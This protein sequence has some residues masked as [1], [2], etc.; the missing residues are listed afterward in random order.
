MALYLSIVIQE[1]DE[2]TTSKNKQIAKNTVALYIRMLFTTI[3]SLYTSRVVLRTLG[4]DD[5]GL[6]GLVGGVVAMLGFINTALSG[7]TSRFITY[8]LG[9]NDRV[10]L[11]K[12]FSSAKLIHIGIAVVLFVV[13]ET[14][15]LWIVNSQLVIPSERVVAANIVYQCSI[16]TS[17]MTILQVPY[18]AS[19][20]AHEKMD[21]YAIIEIVNT[22]LKLLIVYLLLV[23]S[24]DKLIIYSVFLLLV[25]VMV[26]LTYRIY[27]RRKFEECTT[28]CKSDKSVLKPMLVFAGWDLYGN[29]SVTVRQQGVNILL[30][31]FYGLAVN[32]AN[33]I[34][35][36]FN[37]A[38]SGFAN[39]IVV[40][41]RPQIVKSYS[42][43]D[44][45][46]FNTLLVNAIQ[47]SSLFVIM[48]SIPCFF[49]ME[50]ILEIWLKEVPEYTTSFCRISLIASCF[51]I[52]NTVIGAGIHATGDVKRISLITGT[53]FLST[54]FFAYVLLRLGFE[55]DSVYVAYCVIILGVLISNICI[56]KQQIAA[57]KLRLLFLSLF[58]VLCVTALSLLPV[59]LCYNSLETGLL[60]LLLVCTM[61]ALSIS[62][63]TYAIVLNHSQREYVKSLVKEKFVKKV[64]R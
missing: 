30:N 10:R 46:R 21:V 20:I 50:K 61:S 24:S 45:P 58:K 14:I 52:V 37:G 6:Y 57:V 64:W 12:T 25:A 2:N 41:F 43:S 51:S 48:L 33:S 17:V 1:L 23:I 38:L 59:M 5:F 32:A 40:A 18:N 15:G 56:L 27:C 44:W 55:A 34:T 63:T 28:N 19:I 26:Y 29:M 42:M 13:A 47:F 8:E 3:V 4:V 22:S 53:L 7:A 35:T 39:N 9:R 62:I 54:L 11:S 36:M 31:I 49:E 16:L 60:R